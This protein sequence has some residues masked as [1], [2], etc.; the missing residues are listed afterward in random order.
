MDDP[1]LVD[2]ERSV[3]PCLQRVGEAVPEGQKS[4]AG[5]KIEA[6]NPAAL[7]VENIEER[8]LAL[9]LGRRPNPEARAVDKEFSDVGFVFHFRRAVIFP[10]LNI[11]FSFGAGDFGVQ[12]PETADDLVLIQ[13][14]DLDQIIEAMIG[15]E[16]ITFGT[17]S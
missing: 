4:P 8:A 11:I 5:S 12:A 16:K 2:T 13:I 6:V 1:G 14:Q 3:V 9:V 10:K 7:G 17:N 15:I